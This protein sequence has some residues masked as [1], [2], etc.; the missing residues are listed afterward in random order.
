LS[1]HLLIV[2]NGFRAV[3]LLLGIPSL[4]VCLWLTVLKI[5]LARPKPD[6][7]A[8]SGSD[9]NLG[10]DGIVGVVGV[11]ATVIVKPLEF[12]GKGVDWVAGILDIVAAALTV[13]GA[14]LFLTGRG[15]VLHATW[16]RIAASLGLAAHFVSGDDCC[17]TRCSLR[18]DPHRRIDLYALGAD[19]KILTSGVRPTESTSCK[20]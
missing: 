11:V 9:I 16:A 7:S 18:L 15:L 2:A 5:D 1:R 6:P 12:I 13:A 4:L 19:P 20:C 3:G 14:C 10:R 8:Q 17:A